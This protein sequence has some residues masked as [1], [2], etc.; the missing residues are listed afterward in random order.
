MRAPVCVG[1][2]ELLD[3]AELSPLPPPPP[4]PG[5][6]RDDCFDDPSTGCVPA[7]ASADR[8]E[9][10]VGGCCRRVAFLEKQSSHA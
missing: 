8:V 7:G 4:P 1:G 5:E 9:A 3:V 2:I 10:V 6:E